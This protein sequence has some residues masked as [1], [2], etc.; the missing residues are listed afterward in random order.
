MDLTKKLQY[1]GEDKPVINDAYNVTPQLFAGT[2]LQTY[3]DTVQ[4]DT[5]FYLS[6]A[7]TLKE[8]QRVAFDISKIT[9]DDPKIWIAY[10]KASSKTYKCEFNRDT[11][12]DAI[13]S[14]GYE[15]VRQVAL[16]DD[17]S[18]LRFRRIKHIT[19]FTRKDA[20]TREGAKR[21]N[22]RA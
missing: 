7:T 13:G 10:P 4:Q 9:T 16:N 2:Q 3:S 14:L 20:I 19:S 1:K 12:W 18:A 8:I 15:P 22:E 21:I 17:W 11:G 6:L 5:A